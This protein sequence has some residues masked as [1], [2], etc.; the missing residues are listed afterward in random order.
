MLT[1]KIKKMIYF[2]LLIINLY[3]VFLILP[4]LNNVFSN[5][6]AIIFPFIFA[7]VVAFILQ[8]L[9]AFIQKYVKKRWI[10]VIIVVVL[11]L[12]FL[13]IFIRY[14]LNII[15]T[16]FQLLSDKLPDLI[17]EFEMLINKLFKQIP[18]L[19]NYQ[20]SLQDW[21][22]KI[23]II[24]KDQ[25]TSVILSN[26]TFSFITNIGKNIIITSVIILY[27]LLDYEK[28]I[29]SIRNYL[30]N[31]GKIRFKNYLGDLHQ[32]MSAYF[33]GVLLVMFILLMVFTIVFSIIGLENAFIFALIIS[34]TNIIPYLGSW[35]GTCLPVLYALLSSTKQ[36]VIVL[37]CCI[38]I[39]TLEAD[40]LTPFIQGKKV[41]MHPLMIVFSLLLFG[42]LFGFVGMI[43]AVPI[44]AIINITLKH[45]PLKFSLFRN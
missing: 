11:V 32:T 26:Q 19:E 18:F 43:A 12:I 34:F 37:I 36:A 39:Q 17:L 40:L 33:R 27:L 20:I 8:P 13:F 6:F 16:E 25:I 44:T 7:F 4:K 45:Y 38:I 23:M 24:D 5:I 3:L 35:I 31:R 21:I 28:I 1:E 15:I 41:K 42:T 29:T 2:L 14:L 9:I 22:D 10:A 30:V